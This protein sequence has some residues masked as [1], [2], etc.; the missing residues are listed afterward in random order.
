MFPALL[1][2]TIVAYAPCANLLMAARLLWVVKSVASGSSGH[3]LQVHERN[4]HTQIGGRDIEALLYTPSGRFPTRAIIIVPG[5]S[6]QGC[7]HPSLVA[8]SRFL[9]DAG[10]LVLT[11]D[12]VAFR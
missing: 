7:H 4:V 2:I 5:I 11:P 9:A 6:E 10:F 3:N 8:L 1:L 12:I